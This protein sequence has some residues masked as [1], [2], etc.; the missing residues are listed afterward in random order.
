MIVQKVQAKS[1]TDGRSGHL[2]DLIPKPPPGIVFS[3][4]NR[5]EQIRAIR[6]SEHVDLIDLPIVVDD[7]RAVAYREELRRALG[8]M[9]VELTYT[10]IYETRFPIYTLKLAWF[11]RRFDGLT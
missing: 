5:V 2:I 9:T 8:N 3:N 11:H 6:P 1:L 10:D 4:F 7:P